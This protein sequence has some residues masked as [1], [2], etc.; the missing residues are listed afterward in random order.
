MLIDVMVIQ[1]VSNKDLKKV[2]GAIQEPKPI[3]RTD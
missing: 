3:K 1:R 2:A